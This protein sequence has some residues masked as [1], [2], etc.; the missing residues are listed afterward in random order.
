MSSDCDFTRLAARIREQGVTD[1]GFGKRNTNNAF[2][3]ACSKFTYFGVLNC[4]P[5]DPCSDAVTRTT[6]SLPSRKRP[7]DE[8]GHTRL[9]MAV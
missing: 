6:T 8:A 3:A 5:D 2:I 4:P 7:L 1:Y 9:I